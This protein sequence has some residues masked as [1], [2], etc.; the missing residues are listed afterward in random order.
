MTTAPR[1]APIVGITAD[2]ILYKDH[3][4]AAASIA[5]A[6]AVARAGGTPVV[7]P[8]IPELVEQHAALCDAFVFTGGDD[9][10]T[11][12]FG[13]PTHPA[14]TP[15][16]PRRQAYET[17]LLRTLRARP[18]VPALGVCLGMQ[19]M[20]L[21]GGG[22]LE[23]HLPDVLESAADHRAATHTIVPEPGASGAALLGRGGAVASRH[24]QAVR[25]PG[26]GF[27][28]LARSHDGVIE[29]VQD[30]GRKFY[31]GVQWHPERTPDRML[32]QALFDALVS[33]AKG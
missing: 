10:R 20:T 31:V 27:R 12:E 14:A 4:R 29:A 7:L 33:A 26:H 25:T 30:P 17:A 23:Q 18:D 21:V 15:M 13:A 28:V 24:H 9:P 16:D 1:A 8:P 3:E 32:G 6:G 22:E 2:L 19:M 5:F 11:E